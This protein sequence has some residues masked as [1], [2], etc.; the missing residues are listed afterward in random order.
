VGEDTDRKHEQQPSRAE[1]QR[2]IREAAVKAASASAKEAARRRAA[3]ELTARKIATLP[4]DIQ[5]ELRRGYGALI[6]EEITFISACALRKG[7]SCTDQ[8]RGYIVKK[9]G[10]CTKT[11]TRWIKRFVKLK[12]LTSI[13]R[14]P[15]GWNRWQTNLTILSADLARWT[16]SIYRNLKVSHYPGH[17]DKSGDSGTLSPDP[18]PKK[19]QMPLRVGSLSAM[20]EHYR[21]QLR[22]NAG[23][24]P[25][26]CHS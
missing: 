20:T 7:E 25:A 17:T 13:Q 6:L 9:V 23:R 15:R 16:R 12:L 1:Q 11:V 10:C 18:P 26:T 5:Q 24:N 22:Q 8:G 21:Q 4:A 3:R 14:G 2:W 19:E